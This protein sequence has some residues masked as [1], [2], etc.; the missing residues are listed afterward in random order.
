MLLTT[1]ALVTCNL[2]G[3]MKWWTSLRPNNTLLFIFLCVTVSCQLRTK[4]INH[5]LYTPIRKMYSSPSFCACLI[6][7]FEKL[8]LSSIPW[9]SSGMKWMILLP[10]AVV[11][12]L[13]CLSRSELQSHG[14]SFRKLCFLHWQY[15]L[16][17]GHIYLK[18]TS[19]S[20]QEDVSDVG[21]TQHEMHLVIEA[22]PA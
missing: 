17:D 15:L 11:E 4:Y 10:F 13:L 8:L 16:E 20:F 18:M 6:H 3:I 14:L 12:L 1:K 19:P 2:C 5:S 7:L 22:S 21:V 9:H